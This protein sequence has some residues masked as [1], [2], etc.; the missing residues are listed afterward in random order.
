MALTFIL[1]SKQSDIEESTHAPSDLTIN[2]D[3]N[4]DL[5]KNSK[6]ESLREFYW[7]TFTAI[8]KQLKEDKT[9]ALGN[10]NSILFESFLNYFQ[11][12]HTK[13]DDTVTLE[14]FDMFLNNF[15]KFV[16]K[17]IVSGV[18]VPFIINNVKKQTK[19]EAIFITGN[20]LP[21]NIPISTPLTF[22]TQTDKVLLTLDKNGWWNP[23]GGHI[24]DGETW[25]D[26]L[27]RESAEEG[28]ISITN[29]KVFGHVQ[30][31][32]LSVEQITHYPEVT[33]IPMTISSISNY[34]LNW[35]PMET[36]QRSLFT[37]SDCYDALKIR[38]D[39]GQMLQIFSY[40]MFLIKYNLI[41]GPGQ[42]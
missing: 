1:N 18:F 8:K 12:N 38:T 37:H 28:G 22:P 9:I 39:N 36:S 7:T 20:S 13:K 33:Q 19:A 30:I 40:L 6:S 41:D 24:E 35:T 16:N 10:K 23:L 27:A 25:Q 21:T 32:R 11:I 14:N 31:K 5:R 26:A 4:L 15:N 42:N 29:I 34:D 2:L 17:I 3:Q